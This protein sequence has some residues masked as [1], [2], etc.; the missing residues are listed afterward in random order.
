[1]WELGCPEWFDPV[2]WAVSGLSVQVS[3][4][5]A[6]CSLLMGC[7]SSI[8]ASI[9]LQCAEVAK[10]TT[11][12]A[13]TTYSWDIRG[14]LISSTSDS[15]GGTQADRT[16]ASDLKVDELVGTLGGQKAQYHKN[17]AT[18]AWNTA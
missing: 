8:R 11:G 16:K 6:C 18:A 14:C 2:A 17:Q 15:G 9:H 5:K 7:R 10:H 12:S 1:M 13:G 4:D 3:M